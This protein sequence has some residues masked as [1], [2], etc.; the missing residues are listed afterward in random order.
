MK[1]IKL[2]QYVMCTE[3]VLRKSS[4]ACVSSKN[5]SIESMTYMRNS[6]TEVLP[7]S[8]KG[9]CRETLLQVASLSLGIRS[10]VLPA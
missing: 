4:G 2:N 5:K 1:I 8:R 10:G 6:F 3:D 7:I 9:K